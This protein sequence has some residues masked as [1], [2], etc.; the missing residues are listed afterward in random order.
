MTS[1]TV[2]PEADELQVAAADPLKPLTVEEAKQACITA[3]ARDIDVSE[4]INGVKAKIDQEITRHD[5][6]VLGARQTQLNVKA[7]RRQLAGLEAERQQGQA[8]VSQAETKLREAEASLA[9]VDQA[10]VDSAFLHSE[11]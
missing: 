1:E 7:Y 5:K 8:K 11:E 10:A 4:L 6:C 2:S 9:A 3:H